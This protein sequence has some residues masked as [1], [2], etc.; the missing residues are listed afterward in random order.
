MV[1]KNCPDLKN[2]TFV[3]LDP[4]PLHLIWTTS[5][6]NHTVEL[7]KGIIGESAWGAWGALNTLCRFHDH[8]GK[9]Q[10]FRTIFAFHLKYGA[11][12]GAT[13]ARCSRLFPVKIVL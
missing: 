10:I 6:T 2:K 9:I 1:F 4:F 7:F 3:F 11:G 8:A 12:E 5:S 13:A